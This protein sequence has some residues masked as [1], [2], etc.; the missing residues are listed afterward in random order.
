MGKYDLSNI[1]PFEAFPV[2]EILLDE[3]KARGIKQKEL[4]KKME[5]SASVL[6]EILSGK[7]RLNAEYAYAF[8]MALGIPA[9]ELLGLQADYDLNVIRIRE[10][11]MAEKEANLILNEYNQYFDI[12]TII[13]S[14]NL[15][16][17][18]NTEIVA[19]FKSVLKLPAPTHI[20][21]SF[22]GCFK[23][24]EAVGLDE[25]M[26]NTWV[27]LANYKASQLSISGSFDK[28]AM[29]EVA[30]KL[31]SVF[32]TNKDTIQSVEKILSGYGI[33]FGCVEKI[34]GASIDGYST[35]INGVPF[36]IV[37]KRYDRID[38]LA[39]TVM[40]E[41]GH[42][43]LHNAESRISIVDYSSDA[44]EEKEANAFACEKLIAKKVWTKAPEVELNPYI[45][46]RVYTKWATE[47]N[48]N[49]W[50]VLGRISHETGMYKF[51]KDSSR[52]IS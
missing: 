21:P 49:K 30:S 32:H 42:I 50:I 45:I 18:M 31:A 28:A 27:V 38:N 14:L 17:C 51:K 24:S 5:M 37:T 52:S 25:R 26:I 23:K 22:T 7:R 20:Q 29:D 48:L 9:E 12:K 19:F 41:L 1:V 13:K 11:D 4:A 35:F 6:N 47:N 10:R 46:Q 3:I 39:F 36:I 43:Y 44:K 40:H 16:N 34:N 33:G 8:E 15:G 2:G